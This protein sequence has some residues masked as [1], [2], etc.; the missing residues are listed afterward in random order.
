MAREF[1]KGVTHA[2]IARILKGIFPSNTE[3]RVILDL[4]P[5]C[6]K[7]KRRLPHAHSQGHP[8]VT[9]KVHM[10]QTFMGLP[11]S[12]EWQD[13]AIWEVFFKTCQINTFVEFGTG[14]GGFSL[15]LA[16]HC[17]H[18][19]IEF[20]TFDNQKF[21]DP[22]VGMLADLVN[23]SAY[24]FHFC[25][26]FKEGR[27][28]VADLINTKE[29]PMAFFFDDGNKPLEWATFGPM[30]KPGDYCIV[31]DWGTEFKPEHVGNLSV[32]RILTAQSD[33]RGPGWKSMWFKRI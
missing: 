17:F 20:H 6:P 21:F 14:N 13:I 2:D 16:L 9:G 26:I 19:G 28:Q 22:S 7:C 18:R 12:Q 24:N 8:K 25:D 5:I 33:S 31:H 4:S 10:Q 30:T 15:L 27:Q 23:H 11:M 3:K 29:H 1:G 32:V